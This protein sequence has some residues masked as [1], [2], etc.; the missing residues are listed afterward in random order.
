MTLSVSDKSF[1]DIVT[2]WMSEQSYV[3]LPANRGL[4][5]LTDYT[6]EGGDFTSKMFRKLKKSITPTSYISI[7]S[8]FNAIVFMVVDGPLL[9]FQSPS[10]EKVQFKVT[11]TRVGNG[12]KILILYGHTKYDD[13]ISHQSTVESSRDEIL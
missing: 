9:V 11:I 12:E 3:I 1:D 7:D 6:R 5:L 10:I 8:R 2:I 4:P 13:I